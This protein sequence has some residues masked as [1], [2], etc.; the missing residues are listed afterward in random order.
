MTAAPEL[1]SPNEWGWKKE[2]EESWKVRV[3]WITLPENTQACRKLIHA[4]AARA[5]NNIATAKKL[6]CSILLFVCDLNFLHK[7]WIKILLL[8]CAKVRQRK[9]A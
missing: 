2:T 1:P 8:T 6:L 9:C 4:I 5:A 7:K 3:C